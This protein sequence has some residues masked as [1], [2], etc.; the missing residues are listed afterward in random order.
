MFSENDC[1]NDHETIS[2]NSCMEKLLLNI[3]KII[4]AINFYAHFSQEVDEHTYILR[5]LFFTD[6]GVEAPYCK[7]FFI[8]IL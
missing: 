2:I 8:S 7:Y 3:F 6:Q 1:I 4:N 5:F